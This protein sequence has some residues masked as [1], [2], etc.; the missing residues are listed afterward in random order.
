MF[1]KLLYLI[2]NGHP[3]K[4]LGLFFIGLFYVFFTFL[5]FYVK[6]NITLAALSIFFSITFILYLRE[7]YIETKLEDSNDLTK[8]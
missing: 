3:A 4:V 5:Y 2:K 8:K 1:K 7:I 6:K